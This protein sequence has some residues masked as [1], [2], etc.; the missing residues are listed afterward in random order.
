MA[1]EFGTIVQTSEPPR[2]E[3]S[4]ARIAPATLTPTAFSQTPTVFGQFTVAQ[5]ELRGNEDVLLRGGSKEASAWR[6]SPSRLVRK[7]R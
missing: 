7:A 6:T 3:K 4:P 2:G 5:G 1:N